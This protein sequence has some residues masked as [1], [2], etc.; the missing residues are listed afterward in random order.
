MA[1]IQVADTMFCHVYF[2]KTIKMS[3]CMIMVD[4]HDSSHRNMQEDYC[5]IIVQIKDYEALI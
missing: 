1:I 2:I 3:V 4:T 5:V